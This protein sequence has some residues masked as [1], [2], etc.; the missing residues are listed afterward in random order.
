MTAGQGLKAT[1]GVCD[2]MQGV[3]DKL[4]MVIDGER[5]AFA[6]RRPIDESS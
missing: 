3:D 5:K 2:K 4:H 6:N 1:H